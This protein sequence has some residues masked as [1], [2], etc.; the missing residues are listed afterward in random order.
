MYG[1]KCEF[2]K[3]RRNLCE[4]GKL[5]SNI[6]IRGAAKGGTNGGNITKRQNYTAKKHDRNM[7]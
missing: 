4:R 1:F 3:I 6:K 2:L 7:V 5:S